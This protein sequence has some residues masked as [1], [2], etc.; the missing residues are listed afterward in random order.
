MPSSSTPFFPELQ[1]SC[2]HIRGIE[3]SQG[4]S[5]VDSRPSKCSPDIMHST[6]DNYACNNRVHHNLNKH[7][8]DDELDSDV[9]HINCELLDATGQDEGDV[10]LLLDNDLT[11]F[12][13]YY[14]IDEYSTFMDEASAEEYTPWTTNVMITPT[15]V[16][17]HYPRH[18]VS[19]S[20]QYSSNLTAKQR[21]RK[22][23]FNRSQHSISKKPFKHQFRMRKSHRC[24]PYFR[25]RP[26]RC[27]V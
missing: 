4:P 2:A 18:P 1:G 22:T 10:C 19:I 21:S 27:T 6:N 16:V 26:P 14:L 25:N 15:P 17:P 13:H 9:H 23:K 5:P 7:V 24:P 11:E 3:D 8:S 20:F 12:V